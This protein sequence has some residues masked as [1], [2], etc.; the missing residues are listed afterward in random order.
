MSKPRA[1]DTI[2]YGGLAIGIL[3]FFDA[4]IFF[5]LYYGVSFVDV[6]HGPA[7][8]L[9]GRDASRSGGLTTALLG[10]LLHFAVAF[11]IASV[12]FLLSRTLPFL[13]HHPIISGILFGVAAHFVMQYVVI[14]F[15]AIHAWPAWPPVGSLL[16]SL[17]G[18][19]LLVGSPVAL[20]ASWSTRRNSD[21]K[22]S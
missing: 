9:I 10:I 17:I 4:S 2:V 20:I 13:I 1:F 6:W 7:A 12:Y 21:P 15:S 16:N 5:P 8:G 18:H 11:C 14:P 22:P 3:D 19:A